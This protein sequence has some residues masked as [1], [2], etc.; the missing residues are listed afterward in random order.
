[1]QP[2]LIALTGAIVCLNE[3]T[4]R[5][6]GHVTVTAFSIERMEV[7]IEGVDVE[8][9]SERLVMLHIIAD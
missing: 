2:L 4:L 8:I 3:A 9:G 1:M 6:I 7:M 5:L